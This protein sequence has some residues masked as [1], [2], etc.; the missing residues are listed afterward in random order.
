[1]NMYTAKLFFFILLIVMFIGSV[2]GCSATSALTGLI[3]SKP[4]VSAQVGAENTKQGV[5]VSGKVD[6]SSTVKDSTVGKVDSSNGKKTSASSITA[7]RI[8]AEKIEIR[9]DAYS[10]EM[11]AGM[12]SLGLIV[13]SA[14]VC[15]YATRRKKEKGA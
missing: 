8:T 12:F 6:Q 14:I 4:E 5:G 11:A 13:G 7:D 9:N 10:L 3:G 1:M 2:S 15:I